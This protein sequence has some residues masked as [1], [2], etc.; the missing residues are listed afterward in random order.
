[1]IHIPRLKQ[2]LPTLEDIK[3][4]SNISPA[5]K[6]IILNQNKF[7]ILKYV[8]KDFVIWDLPGG[9]IE[10][11]E[12]PYKTLERE[13]ME[14]TSLNI[15]IVKPIGI[16]WFTNE[17]TSDQIYCT[18]FLCQALSINVD[19]SNNPAD[20]THTEYRWVTKKEFLNN[21]EYHSNRKNLINLVKTL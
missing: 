7:L 14:E 17:Q 9:R 11:N 3:N 13:V 6:A 1:M 20:K 15:K 19:I 10:S 21:S 8:N 5:V 12:N 4:M 18:T 16:W 2:R